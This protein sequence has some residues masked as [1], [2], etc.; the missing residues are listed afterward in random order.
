[1]E[2]AKQTVDKNIPFMLQSNGHRGVVGFRKKVI[3]P[4]TL[5]AISGVMVIDK[6]YAQP[7]FRGAYKLF[8]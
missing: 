7:F 6:T 5:K 2:K 4:T 8:F 3:A 1:M